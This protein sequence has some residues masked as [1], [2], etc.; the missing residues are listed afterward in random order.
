MRSQSFYHAPIGINEMSVADSNVVSYEDTVLF[1]VTNFQ[2]IV[3]CVTFSK[4]EPFRKPFYTNGL[5]MMAILCLVVFDSVI[6]LAPLP[7]DGWIY[8]KFLTILPCPEWYRLKLIAGGILLNSVLT[9]AVEHLII[10][11]F[12]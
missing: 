5:Y 4:G 11:N 12:V 2:Y 10:A 6:V 8:S 9:V 3:T 7:A 1:M